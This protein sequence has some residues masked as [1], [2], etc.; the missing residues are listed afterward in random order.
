VA[1]PTRTAPGPHQPTRAKLTLP[2]VLHALA[3]PL[4]L[5]VV[6]RLRDIDERSCG[7]FHDVGDVTVAT[8]SHHLRVLREAGVTST[9]LDGKYRFISLRVDDLDARF[10]GVIDAIVRSA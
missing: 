8:L 4:R 9:R 3:D 5:E 1:A 6:R 7:D 2:T 10:P